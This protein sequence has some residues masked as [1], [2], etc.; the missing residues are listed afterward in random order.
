MF[1]WFV[2]VRYRNSFPMM[3]LEIFLPSSLTN[4]T[5]NNS[6]IYIYNN[7]QPN[8]RFQAIYQNQD[9]YSCSTYIEKLSVSCWYQININILLSFNGP[10]KLNI[11]LHKYVDN[12]E[13]SVYLV[14]SYISVDSS[15]SL[16]SIDRLCKKQISIPRDN[17]MEYC[18]RKLQMDGN[19]I[20]QCRIIQ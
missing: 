3:S 12:N 11:K 16:L 7:L 20:I 19:Y 4:S 14:L 13:I 17:K 1:G 10:H 9:T 5:A 6:K 8:K 15:L 18:L 2:I